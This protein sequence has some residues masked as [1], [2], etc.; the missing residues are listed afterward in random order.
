M[1]SLRNYFD[2]VR[3]VVVLFGCLL[4]GTCIAVE[5]LWVDVRISGKPVPLV[6]DTGAEASFLYR[7]VATNLGLKVTNW[8][9]G[10]PV[11][12][13]K[14]PYGITEECKITIGGI[15]VTGALGVLDLPAGLDPEEGG[16][17]G[18]PAL[19]KNIIR[20]DALNCS[21]ELLERLPKNISKWAKLRLR[22]DSD[23]LALEIL[24]DAGENE[25]VCIDTGSPGGISLNPKEW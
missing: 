11:D 5:R 19:N 2:P 14:F 16:V 18:W 21:F 24:D 23:V 4:V 3:A 25:T 12:P 20:F 22:S 9:A 7:Q 17:L 13:G 6:F 1:I 8:P 10:Q 15:S